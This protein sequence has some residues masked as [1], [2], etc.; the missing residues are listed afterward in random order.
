VVLRAG[1]APS[2]FWRLTPYQ[3]RL[4]LDSWRASERE[5]LRSLVA[6]SWHTANLTASAS[7][8][9]LPRLDE[10]DRRIF[11]GDD[12]PVE[13]DPAMILAQLKKVFA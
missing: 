12:R 8:G 4:A 6:Q 7:V 9:K 1:I 10:Y 11:G 13:T 2:E 5:D 3:S